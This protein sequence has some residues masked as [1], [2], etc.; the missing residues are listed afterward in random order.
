[1]KTTKT[2][3]FMHPFA[4]AKARIGLAWSWC[5]VLTVSSVT[6][7]AP[8]PRHTI[9]DSSRGAD[10][11]RLADVDGNGLPDVITGWEEGGVVRVCFHPGADQVRQRWPAVTVGRAPSPEDA[12]A[13][14]LDR[15]GSPDV[16]SC[17]EGKEQAIWFHWNPGPADPAGVTTAATGTAGWLSRKVPST[18]GETQW[19]Y[20]LAMQ[21]DGQHGVDLV[22]GSKG[23]AG[24]RV[25]W[26]ECPADP[27]DVSAWKLHDIEKATWIMSLEA[28]DMNG[29]GREDLFVTDRKGDRRGAYWL[30]KKSDGGETWRRHDI[31]LADQEVMFAAVLPESA[32]TPSRP[33]DRSAIP[34]L[35]IATRNNQFFHLRFRNDRWVP[36]VFTN[37]FLAKS[38]KAVAVAPQ[39]GG[40]VLLAHTSNSAYSGVRHRQPAVAVTTLTRDDETWKLGS[41]IDVSGLEG[42]KFDRAEWIDL[43]HDG[44]LDLLTCE[45]TDNL[46]VFW[47][48]QP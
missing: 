34:G 13:V 17:H 9:D 48:E 6:A 35:W 19:M 24:G 27:R 18:V 37:P 44:D 21:V 26:L 12:F 16:V 7:Q 22:I 2:D 42:T 11:V 23:T 36:Q 47:Y 8:W 45:E 3:T 33:N 15:D 20:G 28:A 10:G 14:D 41:W 40:G 43:D 5:I 31:A 32:G 1:M 4:V 29:D 46:G 39:P 30:Q 25:A 38:G